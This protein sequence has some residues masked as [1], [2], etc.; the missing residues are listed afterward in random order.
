MKKYGHYAVVISEDV[1][2]GHIVTISA[3]SEESL[4]SVVREYPGCAW[5]MR[6]VWADGHT[7]VLYDGY[8]R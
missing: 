4:L 1:P 2:L 6:Y 8:T 3:D 5:E 7:T